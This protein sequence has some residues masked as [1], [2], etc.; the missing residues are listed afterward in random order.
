MTTKQKYT[1]LRNYTPKKQKN[2]ESEELPLIGV[3][4]QFF[5]KI[6]RI[7]R[8]KI[9]NIPKTLLGGLYFDNL[10][11]R[12]VFVAQKEGTKRYLI[13]WDRDYL[14]E[15]CKEK[16]IIKPY[17]DEQKQDKIERFFQVMGLLVKDDIFPENATME[18]FREEAYKIMDE[19][20]IREFAHDLQNGEYDYELAMRRLC[21]KY[22]ERNR[23]EKNTSPR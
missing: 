3:E 5:R 17:T 2:V 6:L 16:G 12:E 15:F 14:K 18:D 1:Y 22:E 10:M 7:G 9:D 20:E 8:I 21:A 11:R 19:E 13:L 23:P 4:R